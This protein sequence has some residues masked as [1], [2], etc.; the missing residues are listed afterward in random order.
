MEDV[1]DEARVSTYKK[2]QFQL[3]L[4]VSLDTVVK[5]P[6]LPDTCPELA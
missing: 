6:V 1:E 3:M 2:S 4:R 5:R